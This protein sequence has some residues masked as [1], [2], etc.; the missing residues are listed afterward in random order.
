MTQS[1]MA[2]R[3]R[4]SPRKR[5]C[6]ASGPSGVPD[7]DSSSDENGEDSVPDMSVPLKF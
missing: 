7:N 1:E 2:A 5:L 4:S 3:R 6:L